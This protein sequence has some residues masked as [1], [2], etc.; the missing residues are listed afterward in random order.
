MVLTPLKKTLIL[1]A[2]VLTLAALCPALAEEADDDRPT[3]AYWRDVT[4]RIGRLNSD[5]Q[6]NIRSGPGTDYAKVGKLSQG[7]EFIVT[8]IY[9]QDWYAISFDGIEGYASAQYI[10]VFDQPDQ[11]AALDVPNIEIS[12]SSV[13]VP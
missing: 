1:C 11:V 2:L 6:I 3:P 7:D 9:N 10:D 8:G 4:V 12:S 13:T 5:V